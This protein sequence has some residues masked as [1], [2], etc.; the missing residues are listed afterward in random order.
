MKTG[1]RVNFDFDG[2]LQLAR[3]LWA[4]A[5]DLETEDNGR[6]GEAEVAKA[7]WRGAYGDEFARRRDDEYTS[8][9]RV[10]DGLRRDAK[11]WAKAWAKAMTQQNKNNR[12]A[13]VEQQKQKRSNMEKFADIFVGDD[14]DDLVASA[15]TAT[16]PQPP[17]FL[18]TSTEQRF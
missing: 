2:A 3:G 8:R 4:L 6:G 15:R 13:K 17:G 5:D 1:G 14:S 11:E 12:A 16:A 18:P 9:T 7:K 10:V